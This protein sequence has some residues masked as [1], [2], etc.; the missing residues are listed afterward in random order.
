[1]SP[2]SKMA[3]AVLAAGLWAFPG[4]ASAAPLVGAFALKDAAPVTVETVQWRGR[5]FGWGLGAGLLA[6]AAVGAAIA[7]PYYYGY[8]PY[9]YYAPGPVYGAPVYGAPVYGAPVYGAPAYGA[10][11]YG[12]GGAPAGGD[13]AAYCAQRFRSYDPSTGTYLGFDGQRHPCP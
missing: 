9:P 10:P 5:G 12:G 11:A 8:G 6:G 13:P 2:V 1:M 7:S 4:A 3:A